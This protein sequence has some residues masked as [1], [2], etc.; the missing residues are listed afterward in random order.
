MYA[1]DPWPLRVVFVVGG[2][3]WLLLVG[4]AVLSL[5]RATA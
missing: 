5:V 3:V 2:V 4:A 1:R